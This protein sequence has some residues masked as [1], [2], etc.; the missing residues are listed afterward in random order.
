MLRTLHERRVGREV[1]DAGGELAVSI[2]EV[3]DAEHLEDAGG[4]LGGH[5]VGNDL[6]DIGTERRLA[7]SCLE[8]AE[9][10]VW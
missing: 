2:A 3:R 9:A 7:D 10:I 5:R 8:H 1:A 6:C 4:W